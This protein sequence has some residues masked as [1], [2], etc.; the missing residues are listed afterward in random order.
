MPTLC[1]QAVVH[2]KTV[3]VVLSP[4][5]RSARIDIDDESGSYPS[6]TMSI[7]QYI[8][9]GLGHD[10]VVRHVLEVVAMSVERLA[11]LQPFDRAAGTR[12]R[13][14]TASASLPC[15]PQCCIATGEPIA[16]RWLGYALLRGVTLATVVIG[17]PHVVLLGQSTG[18]MVSPRGGN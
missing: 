5:S 8:H 1:M 6:R 18:T 16:S 17:A 11:G 14:S 3:Q 13:S 12:A 10:E 4:E 2:G 7:E 15:A 9:A